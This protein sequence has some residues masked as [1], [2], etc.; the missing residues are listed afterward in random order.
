MFQSR[1]GRDSVGD[2][3]NFIDLALDHIAN[4]DHEEQQQQGGGG[5]GG[6]G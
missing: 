4:L 2:G 5:G 1:L 6:G 3:A